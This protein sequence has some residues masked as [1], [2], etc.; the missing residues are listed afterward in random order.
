M[1]NIFYISVV[2]LSFCLQIS[3]SHIQLPP[4]LPGII[5]L[6]AYSPKTAQPLA[7]LAQTLLRNDQD[8]LTPAHAELIASYVSYLNDCHFCCNSHSAAAAHLM[9]GNYEIVQ[10]IKNDLDSAPISEKLK[11]LLKIADAVQESGRAV[12][13][14]HIAQAKIHGATDKEI[15]D[16]VL[17]AAAFCMYNRYVDGLGTWTPEN[18]ELYDQMGQQLADQGYIKDYSNEK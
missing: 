10:A 8:S 1:K 18:F 15:H 5:G 12:S 7:E 4:N 17:I 14:Y 11:A 9:D 2:S 6:L 16:T 3:T 13:P